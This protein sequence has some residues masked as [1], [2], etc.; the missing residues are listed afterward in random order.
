[1]HECLIPAS[2][3]VFAKPGTS[4]AHLPQPSPGPP[5]HTYACLVSLLLWFLSAPCGEAM[6][7]V[8]RPHIPDMFLPSPKP[9]PPPLR[10]WLPTWRACHF[11]WRRSRAVGLS[12]SEPAF[13][14]GG[15]VQS[16]AALPVTLPCRSLLSMTCAW[17]DVIVL[18]HG[19]WA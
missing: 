15:L 11:S 7:S 9:S 13:H 16:Q 19:S 14:A 2:W 4:T 12:G 10:L 5:G 1:M 3:L 17:K 8:W 18:P 6:P